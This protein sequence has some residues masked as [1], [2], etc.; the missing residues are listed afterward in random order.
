MTVAPPSNVRRSATCSAAALYV[1]CVRVAFLPVRPGGC[2]HR[3]TLSWRLRISGPGVKGG[4][5]VVHLML[6]PRVQS[7]APWR[8]SINARAEARSMRYPPPS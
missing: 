6:A 8:L 7:L 2:V 1:K 5:R 3:R 4:L